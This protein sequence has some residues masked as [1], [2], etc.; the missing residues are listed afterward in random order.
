MFKVRSRQVE[1]PLSNDVEAQR[2]NYPVLVEK[3]KVVETILLNPNTLQL[4]HEIKSFNIQNVVHSVQA[5]WRNVK[6]LFKDPISANRLFQ[7]ARLTSLDFRAF[8]SV[9]CF[10]RYGVIR[11]IPLLLQHGNHCQ[12]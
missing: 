1:I 12:W 6:V 8:I 3:I 7:D 2:K 5:S 10:C 9:R 4:H 11:T